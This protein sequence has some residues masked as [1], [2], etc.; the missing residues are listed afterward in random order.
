MSNFTAGEINANEENFPRI[1]P[2]TTYG[3]KYVVKVSSSYEVFYDT[4]ES[5]NECLQRTKE[6]YIWA[7]SLVS[8][9]KN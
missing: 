9:I 8:K 2:T 7:R 6:D 4:L 5:A 3:S 1:E